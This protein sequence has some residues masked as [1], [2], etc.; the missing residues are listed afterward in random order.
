VNSRDQNLILPKT[1]KA[2]A[3]PTNKKYNQLLL[4]IK[5]KGIQKNMYL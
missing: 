3:K 1:A 2:K 5:M 4:L